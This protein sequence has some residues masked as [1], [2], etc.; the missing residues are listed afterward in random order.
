MAIHAL[1]RRTRTFRLASYVAFAA[2]PTAIGIETGAPAAWVLAGA[3]CLLPIGYEL[4]ERRFANVERIENLVTPLI[5][6]SLGLPPVPTIAMLAALLAGTLARCGMRA[7][8]A[9][10]ACLS[11][12]WLAGRGLTTHLAMAA[13]LTADVL[14]VLALV[15]VAVPLAA[16]GYEETLR[17]YRTRRR[18]ADR[19][20][21]LAHDVE[22]FAQFLP[23]DLD[24]RLA[25]REFATERRWVTVVAVDLAEFAALAER[26]AP[27]DLLDVLD[28]F[29]GSLV[30]V[31]NA[32]GGV[33]HKFLGDG[34][35]VCFGTASMIA[36][37]QSAQLAE[38]FLT[39]LPAAVRLLNDH[40]ARAGFDLAMHCRAAAASGHCAIGAIGRGSRRDFTVIGSAVNLASR[41]QAVAP[42]DGAVL[43]TATAAL[44]DRPV[45]RTV[46]VR[47]FEGRLGI[48]VLTGHEVDA[49][50][51]GH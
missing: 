26:L 44:L 28:E 51:A 30:D 22:L 7:L 50:D 18:L 9:A 24:R 49:T 47:G 43:D 39:E 42:R 2:I 33:V 14:A 3:F 29:Y 34:A 16:L 17:Q 4:L 37:R 6:A 10:L 27:E 45:T 15:G 32:H 21:A 19:S 23:A 35:L 38:A 12:G 40:F 46:E 8:R 25:S 1:A 36:R 41:L 48:H 31:V 13:T 5:A 20:A 11:L